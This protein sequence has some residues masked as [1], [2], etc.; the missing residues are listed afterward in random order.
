M[1]FKR[2]S[3]HIIFIFFI[4]TFTFNIKVQS[5]TTFIKGADVSFL[6]Q[7]EDNG[8]KFYENGKAV[9]VLRLFKEHDINFIRL[10]LWNN[11]S[12][13]YNGLDSTLLMAAR[14]KKHGL[15]FLLD[16]H[17]SDTWA[18]PGHQT[19]PLAWQNI[20]FDALK[21]SIYAYTYHVISLLKTQ[22]TL[23]DI[24]QIGNEITSGFLWNDGRVG[25][26]YNTRQQWYNFASLL[27]MGIKGVK[28]ACDGIDSVKIMIHID[29]GGDQSG[30][31]W[32]FDHLASEN[33]NFDIIGLSYYPW[34]QG[35]LTA[36]KNNMNM[37][38]NRYYKKIVIV[39]T[40]YPWTLKG[41]DSK[42]NI[43]GENSQLLKG[44][45]ATVQGQYDFLTDLIN[46]I[47]NTNGGLGAG[48]FYW[49]PDDIS[50]RLLPSSWENNALF[51][52]NGN[53]LNSINAFVNIASIHTE[54]PLKI[55]YSISQNYPNPFNASTVINY[56]IPIETHVNLTVYNLLGQKVKILVNANKR[57]GF[58]RAYF[59]GI[60]L[61][62][63]VYFY[64]FHA[65]NYSRTKKL[66]LLK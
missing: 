53:V 49:E 56:S 13:K 59:N 28:D 66:I 46:I 3:Y 31:R 23:P 8:G 24:V 6:Q 36:L 60:N 52:F 43:V 44:Y 54:N 25:G 11:P 27:K 34:W 57:A 17:Y 10:R 1:L 50:T 35:S 18:D 39:E 61:H 47:K 37:L 2:K 41:A 22:N 42:N 21:D 29:R 62:S 38:A 4:I 58:Y 7:I 30:S 51:D 32:F 40:A 16:F 64:R 65:G 20:S 5:Q 19:K 33:V 45:P 12:G 63:G 15:K 26:I 14:I 48:V 55:N 9:D